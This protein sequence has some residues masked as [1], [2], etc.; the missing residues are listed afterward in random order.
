MKEKIFNIIKDYNDSE[1]SRF[2]NNIFNG[3]YK[4]FIKT[5]MDLGLLDDEE[6]KYEVESVLID[7]FPMTYLSIIYDKNQDETIKLIV[8]KYLSDVDEVG[9]GRY[10]MRLNDREDLSVFFKNDGGRNDMSSRELAKKIFQEDWW[11]AYDDANED[12]FY[13]VVENLDEKNIK[14]LA[15]RLYEDLSNIQ[16]EPE[17]SLL[18]DIA[19]EQGHP[20]YVELSI[21]LLI[22]NIFRDEKTTK[23]ILQH[24][25]TDVS[26]ELSGL[27][28]NALNSAYIDEKWE[29]ATEELKSFLSID[30]IGEWYSNIVKNYKG[31]EK[32]VEN[33]KIEVTKIL[34]EIFKKIFNDKYLMDDSYNIF[35]YHGTLEGVL[36]Y[37]INEDIIEGCELRISSYDYPDYRRISK[38]LNEIFS[39]YVI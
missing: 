3:N 7:L 31:E 17:T 2:V 32:T 33:Y 10:F 21:D 35:E 38:I 29:S 28:S 6:Y 23:Y 24:E 15:E 4:V 14:I 26:S 1:L 13:D 5:V 39:D 16:I 20:E 27:Y 30:N 25:G 11:D 36:E 37:L 34:P 18:E 8:D 12:L 9:D 19:E 22:N